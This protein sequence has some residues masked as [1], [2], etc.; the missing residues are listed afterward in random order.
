MPLGEVLGRAAKKKV[1]AADAAKGER[2][3]SVAVI[4][5]FA[6]TRA[7]EQAGSAALLEK[8][9]GSVESARVVPAAEIREKLG[10]KGDFRCVNASADA[11][12]GASA[13][14]ST[15]GTGWV[16]VGVIPPLGVRSESKTGTSSSACWK[17]SAGFFA[18]QRIT[19]SPSAGGTVAR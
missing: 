3:C 14:K 7:D 8:E 12:G 17:R 13:P 19:I 2:K 15:A 16:P 9:F 18:R 5:S 1:I 11:P 6:N 10:L 4:L